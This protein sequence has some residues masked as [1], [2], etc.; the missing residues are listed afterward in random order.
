MMSRVAATFRLNLV[1]SE[2]LVAAEVLRA[3]IV[4]GQ[5]TPRLREAARVRGVTYLVEA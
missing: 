2:A 4:V 1:A 5:D 3:D